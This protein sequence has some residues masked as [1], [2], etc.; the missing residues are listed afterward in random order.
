[1]C[2]ASLY[3]FKDL[4]K[5]KDRDN[6]STLAGANRAQHVVFTKRVPLKLT[7]LH[8]LKHCRD[9]SISEDRIRRC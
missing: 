9:H 3:L 6:N 8:K 1:M 4:S 7:T 5:S 2:A